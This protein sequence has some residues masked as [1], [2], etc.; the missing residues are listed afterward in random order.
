MSDTG[1]IPITLVRVRNPWGSK[2]EWKGAWG[3]R[4][5]TIYENGKWNRKGPGEIGM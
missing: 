2:V 4:Y 3:D 1:E 5:V